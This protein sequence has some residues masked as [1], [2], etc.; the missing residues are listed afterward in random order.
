VRAQEHEQRIVALDYE[1]YPEMAERELRNI[2]NET[3]LRFAI[4]D[5]SCWH[6]VG[7]VPSESVAESA[8][9]VRNRAEALEAMAFFISALKARVPIWKWAITASG[10]RFP[11]ETRC[12]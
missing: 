7:R 9:L 8:D 6:R 5:L 12:K 2:A 10:E 1:V 3:A 11:C 4:H